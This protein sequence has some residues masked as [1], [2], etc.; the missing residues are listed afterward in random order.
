MRFAK[1]MFRTKTAGGS[2]GSPASGHRSTLLVKGLLGLLLVYLVLCLLVGWYWNREPGIMPL[3][4]AV[5]VQSDMVEGEMTVATVKALMTTLLEKPGGY[6]SNDIMPPGVWLDNMP[7]WEFG[8]LVQVRDFTRAMRRDMA[9][10]QSQSAEDPD[11][12]KAEP[13]FHFDNKS[14]IMPAT[15]SEYR[16]GLK[17]L[18]RYAERLNS[19]DADFYARADNLGSWLGDVSTRLGSLSQRLSAS[20][21]QAPVTDG[22]RPREQTP[23]LEIDDVF[24]ESRGS[25]WALMHLLRAVEVDF[26][27]IIAKKNAQ[28][29]LQQIIRELEATQEP[30]WSP[31][32]LNGGGFGVL[33]NHSLVMANYLSRANAALIDLRRLMEQG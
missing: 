29:S 6:L 28:A 20:V 17:S 27:D 21:G 3:V 1:G 16:Q 7:N 23:W 22:S 25:A 14:W 26:A 24:Y 8:V 19:G 13:L 11:L 32:V 18:N 15:E 2:A 33:A 12:A 4:P 31:M 5:P 9:R 30:L 10:S